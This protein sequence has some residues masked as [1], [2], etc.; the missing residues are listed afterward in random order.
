MKKRSKSYDEKDNSSSYF[1]VTTGFIFQVFNRKVPSLQKVSDGKVIDFAPCVGT[2]IAQFCQ[3][4]YSKFWYSFNIPTHLPQKLLIDSSHQGLNLELSVFG[5]LLNFWKVWLFPSL[6]IADTPRVLKLKVFFVFHKSPL[7]INFLRIDTHHFFH[8][9][10]YLLKGLRIKSCQ[11]CSLPW[12]SVIQTWQKC[13]Q[14][15]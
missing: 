3:T 4:N 13:L 2:L 5:G 10:F 12:S 14:Y 7:Q 8:Q 11:V 1:F 9:D 15:G 6:R